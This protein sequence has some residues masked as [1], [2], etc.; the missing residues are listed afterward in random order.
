MINDEV[1][2]PIKHFSVAAV[3]TFYFTAVI[4]QHLAQHF[5]IAWSVLLFVYSPVWHTSIDGKI[6]TFGDNSDN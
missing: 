4:K 5:I 1:F 6:R 2:K 3:N